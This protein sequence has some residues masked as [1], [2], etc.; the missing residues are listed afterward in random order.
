MAQQETFGDT[1]FEVEIIAMTQ[2][3]LTSGEIEQI[4]RRECAT[5]TSCKP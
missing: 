3:L 4:I 5:R 1:A 2:E